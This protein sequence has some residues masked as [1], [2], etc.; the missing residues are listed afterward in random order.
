MTARRPAISPRD[1]HST[2]LA[3]CPAHWGLR[4]AWRDGQIWG[5]PGWIVSRCRFPNQTLMGATDKTRKPERVT[6][7]NQV[8]GGPPGRQAGLRPA[9]CSRV[10]SLMRPWRVQQAAAGYFKT[11]DYE[12]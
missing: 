2:R 7:Q 10:R 1:F 9:R 3:S 12:F 4:L 6:L 8:K 5:V 11:F